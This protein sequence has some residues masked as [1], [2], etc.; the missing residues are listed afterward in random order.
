MRISQTLVLIAVALHLAVA[1]SANIGADKPSN[2]VV[3]LAALPVLAHEP[4]P[5]SH[6]G[7][8]YAPWTGLVEIQIRN[9]SKRVITLAEINPASEFEVSVVGSDGKEIALTPEGK[10]AAAYAGQFP[11][12]SV[13]QVELGP[14]EEETVR[15]DISRRFEVRPGQAYRVTLRRSKGLPKAGDDGRPLR[16]V[17]VSVS[18]DVLASGILR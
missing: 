12:I 1:Q 18:F 17:S 13:S 14:F 3:E 5:Q 11:M 9:L 7:E 16:D 6:A 8:V 4:R 2:G 15:L 10:R